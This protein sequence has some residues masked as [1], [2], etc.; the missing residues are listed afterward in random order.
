MWFYEG[1]VRRDRAFLKTCLIVPLWAFLYS[2]HFAVYLINSQ[3]LLHFRAQ[4]PQMFLNQRGEERKRLVVFIK[5][6]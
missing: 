1:K 5:P 6:F 3:K 4:I 2:F